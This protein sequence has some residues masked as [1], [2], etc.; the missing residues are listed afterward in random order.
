MPQAMSRKFRVRIAAG[1][2]ALSGALLAT[3]APS[4]RQA[5]PLAPA[6][7]DRSDLGR[8]GALTHLGRQD[9]WITARG[10]VFNTSRCR[11]RR[12]VVIARA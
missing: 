6:S 1:L 2:A 5:P 8:A 11:L 3:Q 7:C 4:A 9:A 10:E 12:S